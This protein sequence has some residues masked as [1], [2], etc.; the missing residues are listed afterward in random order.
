G[1]PFCLSASCLVYNSCL[2]YQTPGP[3]SFLVTEGNIFKSFIAASTNGWVSLRLYA[4]FW[5]SP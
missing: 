5:I 3:N 1:S 4:V 2:V